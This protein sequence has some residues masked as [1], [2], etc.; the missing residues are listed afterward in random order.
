MKK[1]IVL[2]VLVLGFNCAQAQ[3][4]FILESLENITEQFQTE[5]YYNSISDLQAAKKALDLI[6]ESRCLIDEMKVGMDL[7]EDEFGFSCFE[8]S[9]M[10]LIQ[11]EL[12]NS[13]I[14]IADQLYGNATQVLSIFKDII[15]AEGDEQTVSSINKG[16][17]A[18]AIENAR[19]ALKELTEKQEQLLI[20]RMR[21]KMMYYE[22]DRQDQLMMSFVETPMLKGANLGRIQSKGESEKNAATNLIDLAI[23]FL[24]IL[25]FIGAGYTI[26]IKGELSSS[27]IIGIIAALVALGVANA[28]I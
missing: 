14:L 25:V 20:E 26:F 12:D 4:N 28:L 15:G 22:I 2:F 16:V 23:N 7:Y 9:E 17:M 6:D 21:R 5:G 24:T 18:E 19:R 13:A 27:T 1:L 11:A 3:F 10:A 8:K